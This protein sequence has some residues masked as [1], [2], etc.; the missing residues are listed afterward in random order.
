[1]AGSLIGGAITALGSLFG[2][3][4]ANS[5]N[6]RIAREQM[7]F[8]E[9]MSNTAYQRAVNDMKAAGLNPMLAYSQGGASS[10]AGASTRVE[11]AVGPA[12]ERG[13]N[14]ARAGTLQRATIDKL[15][16][17]TAKSV[18]E[19]GVADTQAELNKV[20][21]AKMSEDINL[22]TASAQ[23]LRAQTSYITEDQLGLAQ[24]RAGVYLDNGLKRGLLRMQPLEAAKLSAQTVKELVDAGYTS[25]QAAHLRAIGP[26]LVKGAMLENVHRRLSVPKAQNEAN[27]ESSWWKQHVSPYLND[28]GKVGNAW[29]TWKP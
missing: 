24:K 28:L 8:Q 22:S 1:M 13:V 27:S 19:G 4:S 21:A 20:A 11:D 17:D 6:R 26:E 18:K 5:T 7:Q 14:S 9:R 2:Q 3:S 10:P 16:A 25:D 29:N 12:I 23:H 15:Q